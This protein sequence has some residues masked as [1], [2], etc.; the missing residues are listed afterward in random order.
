RVEL[1]HS[2]GIFVSFDGGEFQIKGTTKKSQFSNAKSIAVK[3]SPNTTEKSIKSFLQYPPYE[4][5]FPKMT[6]INESEIDVEAIIDE[7]FNARMG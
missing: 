4:R 1:L 7:K 6:F 5:A 3:I 2:K